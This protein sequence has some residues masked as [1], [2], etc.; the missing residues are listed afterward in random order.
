MYTLC[1]LPETQWELSR[2]SKMASDQILLAFS[3]GKGGSSLTG[4]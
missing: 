1:T 4:C 2:P 3:M